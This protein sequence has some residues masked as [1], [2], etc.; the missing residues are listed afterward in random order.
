MRM[1]A[2]EKSTSPLADFYRRRNLLIPISAEGSP[3]AIFER[4][5][6]ALNGAGTAKPVPGP[7]NSK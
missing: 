4:T 6:K 3:E 7:R 1:E 2:Y 5:M